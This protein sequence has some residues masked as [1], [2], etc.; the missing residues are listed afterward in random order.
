MLGT[1]WRFT[2]ASARSRPVLLTRSRMSGT[3]VFS[4][5]DKADNVI[6]FSGGSEY[7]FHFEQS[8]ER[9]EE[10]GETIEIEIDG[11]IENEVEVAAFGF[12]VE[13]E[14]GSGVHYEFNAEKSH[15]NA[16]SQGTT[17]SF[18]LADNDAGDEFE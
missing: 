16:Q 4:T 15:A 9:E 14:S 17:M 5:I 1:P 6:T 11:S 3:A 2:T 7:E 13:F 8:T 10:F 12:G 18:V